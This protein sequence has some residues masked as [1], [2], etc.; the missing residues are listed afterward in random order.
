MVDWWKSLFVKNQFFDN[1]DQFLEI[2]IVGNDETMYLMWKGFIEAKIRIF[3]EKL[4][5]LLNH[6]N[7]DM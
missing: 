6:I 4:E 1:Y 3:C 2:I 5:L 7:F